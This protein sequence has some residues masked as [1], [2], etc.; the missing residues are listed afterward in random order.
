MTENVRARECPRVVTDR[1]ATGCSDIE[2]R[3]DMIDALLNDS[4]GFRLANTSF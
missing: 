4:G 2:I 3:D 1:H